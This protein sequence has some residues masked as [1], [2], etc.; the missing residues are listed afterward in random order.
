M[1]DFIMD[2]LELGTRVA[3]ALDDEQNSEVPEWWMALHPLELNDE[4]ERLA[5]CE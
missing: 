1:H 3:Y 5:D 4:P 2:E